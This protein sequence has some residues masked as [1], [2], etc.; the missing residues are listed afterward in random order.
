MKLN[1]KPLSSAIHT[2]WALGVISSMTVSGIAVAQDGDAQNAGAQNAGAQDQPKATEL[3]TVMITGSHIRRVDAETSNPVIQIDSQAIEQAGDLTLGDLIQNL[4]AV[5]G[6]VTNPNINNGGGSGA[7]S[8]GLRG[9]GAARTLVLVNGQRVL[10]NDLNAVPAAAVDHIEVLTTGASSVYGSDAIGGAIN[11]ILKK[12]FQGARLGANYGVSGHGDGQRHGYTFTAG[13]TTEKGSILVGVGYNK[14]DA[15]MESA[16]KF[17]AHTLSITGSTNTPIRSFYGGSSFAPR[18]RFQIPSSL[19]GQFGCS[20]VSLNPDAFTGN[21][22]PTKLS[23]YHCYD[24][25]QDGYSFSDSRPITTPQERTNVFLNAEYHLTDKVSAYVTA[26]HNKTRSGFLLG[27]VVWATGSGPVVS[28]DSM[29]NP[30][31]VDYT[32]DSGYNFR[33]RLT[34]AQNRFT[35]ISTAN[36]QGMF[37]LR[38]NFSLFDRKW[39]WDIGYDYG[40]TSEQDT[41]SGLPNTDFL[42]PGLG[43]SMLVDGM[44]ACVGIPGDPSTVIGGCTPWDT[45]N[46]KNP[47]SLAIVN[48]PNETH[49]ALIHSLSMERIKHASLNGGLFDLPYGTVQL[50]LGVDWR[51][52][53]SHSQVDPVLLADENGQCQYG[54]QCASPLRGGFSVHEAYAE[55]FIPILGEMKGVQELNIDL[56]FRHSDFSNF[57]T[58]NNSKIAIEYRPISSLLLRGTVAEVF[59][60]PTIGNIYAQPRKFGARLNS[61]PCDHITSSNPACPG[62]PTD[63]SFVNDTVASHVQGNVL[64]SGSAYAGF[65]L[66]PETGKSFDF[67]AVYS[68]DFVPGLSVS[69]DTWKIY[70]NDVITGVSNQTVVNACFSGLSRF[71]PLIQR[72][73]ANTGAPGQIQN[74]LLP[75]ANLGRLDVQGTDMDTS[76]RLP[77]SAA[78]DFIFKLQATY[79]KRDDLE[80]AP[81]VA[82]NQ[83]IHGAGTFNLDAGVLG[84]VPRWRS[85]GSV[86]WRRGNWDASWRLHYTG[87]WQ[88]GSHQPDRGFSAVPGFKDPYVLKYGARSVSDFQIGYDFKPIHT[89]FDVGVNNAFDKQPP[90]LYET[91]IGSGNA[92]TSPSNFDPIGRYY[93]ARGTVSF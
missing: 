28:K 33:S 57:G 36:D 5:T 41:I 78:G 60:A 25:A 90:I 14:T 62:V 73:G 15:I 71:C 53:Y 91:N 21:E 17:S 93:W 40:H 81:G 6:P 47:A 56:G 7:T 20:A 82:G 26:Y 31:G 35:D 77:T 3:Q 74:I 19:Q 43:P 22:S 92:N 12:D 83:I 18:G 49:P 10:S 88:L 32:L 54:S 67:G 55:M 38:G 50:A 23:D 68:P 2:V 4:P 29:Y 80:T 8:V 16:R 87:R 84:F 27:P 39:N 65:D 1:R 11:I 30:F 37:G 76:Y 70:L 34:T 89:R 59:R 58:S 64:T 72:F 75:T 13:Q 66:G 51:S 46:L 52:E 44:P 86:S 45:F 48:D 63:G 42:L 9:L 69:V 79:M 24:P 85:E 61:D